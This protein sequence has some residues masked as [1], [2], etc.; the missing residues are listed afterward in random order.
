MSPDSVKSKWCNW[1][2]GEVGRLSKRLVPV[3]VRATAPGSL[4]EAL[5]KIHLLPAQG[6]YEAATHE[7]DLVMAL[8]TD[9]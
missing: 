6:A 3:V 4:P 1:E 7:V 9:R 5:G 8:N 2:L